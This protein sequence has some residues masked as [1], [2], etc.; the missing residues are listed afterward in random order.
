[1]H[2]ILFLQIKNNGKHVFKNLQDAVHLYTEQTDAGNYKTGTCILIDIA[3]YG[4]L[5]HMKLKTKQWKRSLQ[6]IEQT[7]PKYNGFPFEPAL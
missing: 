6:L 7:N 3:G 4:G 2:S 5:S 1:M